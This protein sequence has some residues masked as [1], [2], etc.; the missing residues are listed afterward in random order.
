MQ[1]IHTDD[2]VWSLYFYNGDKEM[3][4]SFLNSFEIFDEK[5]STQTNSEQNS[6]DISIPEWIKNNAG[7]WAEGQI[8]DNSF[9]KGIEYLVKVGII[10]VS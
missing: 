6:I 4:E 9:V 1:E 8:D 7:W 5:F 2:G 3:Y 10:Q